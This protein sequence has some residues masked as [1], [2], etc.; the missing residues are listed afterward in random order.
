MRSDRLARRELITLLAGA[1]AGALPWL[2]AARAQQS[3]PVVGLLR[4]TTAAPFAHIVAAL[5]NGLSDEGFVEGRN[6]VIEQRWADNQPERLPA[7]AAEL[8]R[9]RAAVIVVNS[10]AVAAA[11]RTAGPPV[12]LVFVAGDD[13]IKMGFVA[14][15]SRPEGNITGVTFFGGSVLGSKRLE[16]LHALVPRATL[17]AML[18]DPSTGGFEAGLP[19]IEAAARAFGLKTIQVKPAGADDLDA[20]FDRIVA[21]GAGAVLFG[22]GP[23][24]RSRMPQIIALAARH[25]LPVVYEL[26]DYAEAGG[27][28]SYG[29]SFPGAYRQA[30]AYAGRILKGA[31]PSELPILQ[32]TTFELVINL[33]TAKTLGLYVPPSLLAMADEVIE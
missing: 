15:L 8:I 5:R 30:G 16:L 4:T 11:A 32:P 6:V 13:P 10:V 18:I 29:A 24:L 27:L 12:P 20:A 33:K 3:P 7:L 2:R 23:V 26:R 9:N 14:S 28:V 25:A 1:A 19:S 22:G 17:V 21:S 31:K